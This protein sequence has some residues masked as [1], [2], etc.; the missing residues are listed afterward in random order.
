MS[1][2]PAIS[3][4]LPFR[5]A[6]ATIEEAIR[7]IREQTFADWELLAIDDGSAD[8]SADIV[9]AHAA[10]DARIRLLS[11][12]ARGLVA[13]LRQGC[14]QARGEF[15]A[16]MDADDIALPE[17][18]ARQ[19]ELLARN[20]RMALC[21]TQVEM[22]GEHVGSGRI[23]YQDWLNSLTTPRDTLRDL[24]IEC[25]AA[26][27]AFLMRRDAYEQVGGYRDCDWAEDYDLV[28]RLVAAGF[29]IGNVAQVLLRWRE[30]PARLSRTDARYSPAAFRALKRHYLRQ[31][32]LPEGRPLRQW[33]A[34]DVGKRWLAEW[35]DAAPEFVV[36]V[37][38]RKI[39][40]VIHGVR[41]IAPEELR[42]PDGALLVVA[43]G[44]PGA[45]ALIREFLGSRGYEEPG[46]FLFLA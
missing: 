7:S 18:L 36:D 38:P 17:R 46:D 27:P 37:H 41:V 16:R 24:F 45:R 5:D 31:L 10:Q 43:V 33:G 30:S 34:G 20:P 39:G 32:H 44:A 11:A 26:H 25:P 6:A 3:I 19:V 29:E 1:A 9:R 28:M 42:A 15:I 2:S 35:E 8:E 13:A 12:E 14:A 40:G 23:E 22:F 21:G 4:V